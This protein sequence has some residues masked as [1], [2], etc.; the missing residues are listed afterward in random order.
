MG[1]SDNTVWN[2]ILEFGNIKEHPTAVLP[3]L[4][5]SVYYNTLLC[6][7]AKHICMTEFIII[8]L[9]CYQTTNCG[10]ALPIDLVLSFS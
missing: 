3:M 2:S 7:C 4:V 10:H 8:L 5:S 9:D 1:I 6:Y